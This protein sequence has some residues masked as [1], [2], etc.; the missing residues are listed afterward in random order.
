MQTGLWV[1]HSG[2]SINVHSKQKIRSLSHNGSINSFVT[3]AAKKLARETGVLQHDTGDS[4]K[5]L[6]ISRIGSCM[7]FS[8]YL[9]LAKVTR[10]AVGGV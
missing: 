3:Q 6:D 2:F 1:W 8:K 4:G 10:H 7:G 5:P 9:G